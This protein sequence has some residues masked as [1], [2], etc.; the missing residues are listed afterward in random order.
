MAPVTVQ[1]FGWNLKDSL[2]RVFYGERGER[3]RTAQKAGVKGSVGNRRG[4]PLGL[5]ELPGRGLPH[6]RI[7][8]N[9]SV[10]IRIICLRGE[11]L[12]KSPLETGLGLVTTSIDKPAVKRLASISKRAA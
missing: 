4:V 9:Q 7:L 11:R 12:K 8:P 2:S 5:R 1:P 6:V 10:S 3:L